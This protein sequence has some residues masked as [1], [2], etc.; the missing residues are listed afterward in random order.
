MKQVLNQQGT[1]LLCL[2]NGEHVFSQLSSI[3]FNKCCIRDMHAMLRG[4]HGSATVYILFT[5]KITL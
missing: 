2:V 3:N 4:T 1:V 5:Y